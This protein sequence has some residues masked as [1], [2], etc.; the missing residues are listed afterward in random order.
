MA[1]AN[2]KV[3]CALGATFTPCRQKSDDVLGAPGNCPHATPV[4]F[5]KPYAEG[6]E[7]GIHYARAAHRHEAFD[8]LPPRARPFELPEA[9]A[10]AAEE[11]SLP[12]FAE[13]R[14]A[15]IERMLEACAVACE[16]LEV[17]DA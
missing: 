11:L 2:R 17:A 3:F 7:V 1:S 16:R 9:E 14:V 4:I 8:A 12:M 15:E 5:V 13:L 10:W 6:V